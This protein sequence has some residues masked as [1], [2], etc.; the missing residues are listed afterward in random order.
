MALVFGLFGVQ[1][2][3]A[4]LATA[5]LHGVIV[6]LI[7][8]VAR[9]PQTRA[10]LAAMGGLTGLLNK[11]GEAEMLEFAREIDGRGGIRRTRQLASAPGE[12]LPA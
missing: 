11:L 12:A 4:K 10:Q 6:A 2:A 9:R 8:A 5:L 1:L 3:T 7:Y